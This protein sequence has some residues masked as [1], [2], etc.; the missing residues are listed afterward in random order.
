[1]WN[2][3]IK[4]QKNVL[5]SWLR[6]LIQQW[7]QIIWNT[8]IFIFVTTGKRCKYWNVVSW[9][10]SPSIAYN[11]KT[12]GKTFRTFSF[13]RCHRISWPSLRTLCLR[14][15]FISLSLFALR[16]SVQQAVLSAVSKWCP[17]VYVKTYATDRRRN[18]EEIKY[19]VLWTLTN[20]VRSVTILFA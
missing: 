15:F 2:T 16:Q 6:Y 18:F 10:I 12:I 5:P 8:F 17:N 19:T 14:W 9:F 3:L 4:I 20:R 7:F 11:S 1:M 13:H